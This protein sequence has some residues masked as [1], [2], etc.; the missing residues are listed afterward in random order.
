MSCRKLSLNS[1]RLFS[2]RFP[3]C[4]AV[5]PKLR[6]SSSSQVLRSG[7]SRGPC[8][9][10]SDGCGLLGWGL[11]LRKG[12]LY[13]GEGGSHRS[14]GG[15]APMP[16]LSPNPSFSSML[17]SASQSGCPRSLS[18]SGMSSSFSKLSLSGPSTPTPVKMYQG[19]FLMLNLFN[20]KCSRVKLTVTCIR[21]REARETG[22]WSDGLLSALL[23][24]GTRLR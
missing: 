4:I 1:R 12:A 10:P 3:S 8:C 24:P 6:S 11:P 18:R 13:S 15:G 16:R 2:T 5:S 14:D 21:V 7:A 23:E 17:F 22:L 9:A 20:W 19:I